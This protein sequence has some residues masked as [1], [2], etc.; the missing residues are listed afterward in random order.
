MD[1]SGWEKLSLV[2]Y[3]D[4]LTTTLFMAGCPF[5]CPFCHNGDLVLRPQD[6]PT[7]PWE[8]IYEYLVRRKTML[9][10]VCISGG[11]PT[12]MPDLEEKIRLIKELGYKVKLDS[13]GWK[14]EILEK[15]LHNRLV[16]FI[17]MDIKNAKDKYNITCG[18]SVDIDA[19]SKS[20]NLIMNAGIDYEFRTTII[21]EFHTEEDIRKI[22]EW[23]KGAK[24]YRLQHYVDSPYC[25]Q[26]GLHPVTIEKA[27]QFVEAL[28]PYI[29]NVDLR[30]Y[31]D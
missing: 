2:D 5:R 23:I 6:A 3:D 26:R 21:Q 22:G 15:L 10:A 11:E 7:I 28:R 18:T 9:T 29:D 8:E 19:I 4:N 31:E 14:P 25:I 16:D 24:K 27:L 30:G 1:F 20:V 12:L 13:N 17:A